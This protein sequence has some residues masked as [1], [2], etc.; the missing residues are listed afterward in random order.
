MQH[1]GLGKRSGSRGRVLE[2][3]QDRGNGL[4]FGEIEFVVGDACRDNAL[5]LGNGEFE[6]LRDLIG[7]CSGK[8]RE[9]AAI[10]IHRR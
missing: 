6:D 10:A 4:L 9:Q 3:E 2:A 1:F 8:D 5:H 7:R